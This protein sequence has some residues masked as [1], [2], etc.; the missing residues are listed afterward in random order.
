MPSTF[1][2]AWWTALLVPLVISLFGFLIK[3]LYSWGRHNK[4]SLAYSFVEKSNPSI[5]QLQTISLKCWNDSN[6]VVV[7][8]DFALSS[9][10]RISNENTNFF[11]PIITNMSHR[12]NDVRIDDGP[13]S[14]DCLIRFEFLNPGDGFQVVCG[15]DGKT[16]GVKLKGFLKGGAQYPR[17]HRG[18]H[19]QVILGM[20]LLSIFGTFDLVNTTAEIVNTHGWIS[21]WALGYLPVPTLFTGGTL[22][23]VASL[24]VIRR[25]EP[26]KAI[27]NW[28]DLQNE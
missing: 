21:W 24:L 1:D 12:E 7:A 25:E 16:N 13:H 27:Q 23:F 5:P 17:Y 22:L 9:P 4:L 6:S 11:K 3:A 2:A 10:L 19:P 18:A 8:S 28:P 14:N 20:V 15:H 26:P